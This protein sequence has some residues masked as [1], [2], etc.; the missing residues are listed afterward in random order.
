MQ[1]LR[2]KKCNRKDCKYFHDTKSEK[3]GQNENNTGQ[4]DTKQNEKKIPCKFYLRGK[5]NKGTKCNYHHRNS[6][7]Q[8]SK[9]Q[10]EQGKGIGKHETHHPKNLPEGVQRKL[11]SLTTNITKMVKEVEKMKLQMTKKK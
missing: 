11:H 6:S 5:C 3:Q 8:Q 10:R 7:G 9:D 4:D 2:Q 1:V